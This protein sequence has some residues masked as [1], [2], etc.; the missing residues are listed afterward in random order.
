MHCN[1]V[2]SIHDLCL[3]GDALH[4]QLKEPKH[5]QTLLSG[6][7]LGAGGGEV[8]GPYLRTTGLDLVIAC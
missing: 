7:W 1:M 2:S 6:S 5:L 3:L 8:N 4:P